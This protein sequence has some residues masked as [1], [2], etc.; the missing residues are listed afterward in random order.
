MLQKQVHQFVHIMR[1]AK[2]NAVIRSN[3][4]ETFLNNLLGKK[5]G[6]RISTLGG[7][8]RP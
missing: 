2:H 1:S 6:S 8:L 3:G 5:T 7:W 4:L